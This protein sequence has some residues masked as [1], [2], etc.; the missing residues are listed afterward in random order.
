MAGGETRV[1]GG[2]AMRVPGIERDPA[3]G[4]RI[5]ERRNELGLGQIQLADDI[6]GGCSDRSVHRWEKGEVLSH[7]YLRQLAVALDTTERWL[8]S[9]KGPRE[10][11]T[12]SERVLVE[13]RERLAAIEMRLDEGDG[14]RRLHP[15]DAQKLVEAMAELAATR[16]RSP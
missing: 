15:E 16:R 7:P 5:A 2:L 3:R 14:T 12:G 11:L 1:Y 13:I 4:K 10:H 9:G 6:G 8:I